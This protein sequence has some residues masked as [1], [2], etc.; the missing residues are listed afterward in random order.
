MI[1]FDT[2]VY[3]IPG[4]TQT[5]GTR[6]RL[7]DL[8]ADFHAEYA[9]PSAVVQLQPWCSDWA[10]EAEFIARSSRTYPRIFV[11]AYS[12][13]AGYG[14]VQLAKHLADRGLDVLRAWLIDPVYRHRYWLG[15]WRAFVPSVP[16]TVPANV[17]RVS[18][19]RQ[20]KSYPKGH[21][22]RAA[23][24]S[25]HV[26]DPH[27]LNVGHVHMDDHRPTLNL[28]ASQLRRELKCEVCA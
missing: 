23:A 9:G 8:W 25:T 2:W 19:W 7:I 13:G 6:T 3:V 10:S 14:F 1:Q 5:R 16:I 17:K 11:V 12:W 27:W 18:W 26:E 15:Q 20:D 24:Q 21:D 22:L 28:I 4:F